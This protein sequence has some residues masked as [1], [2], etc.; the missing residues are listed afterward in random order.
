MVG[1]THL[2]LVLALF[3]DV[4]G[5]YSA[6]GVPLPQVL[7]AFLFLYAISSPQAF[8]L[9]RE[10]FQFFVLFLLLTIYSIL[11]TAWTWP[12]EVDMPGQATTSYE[13]F[14]TLGAANSLPI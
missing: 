8:L 14:V 3:F 6:W 9:Q 7:L 5:A 2:F 10:L 11:V 13:A 12:T 1:K 4:L